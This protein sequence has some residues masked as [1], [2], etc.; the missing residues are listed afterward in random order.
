M[1]KKLF[2]R[3]HFSINIK[4]SDAGADVPALNMALVNA[5]VEASES[6]KATGIKG[7]LN[8]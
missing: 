5:C 2:G 1:I 8:G 6:L 4:P 3:G 7:E